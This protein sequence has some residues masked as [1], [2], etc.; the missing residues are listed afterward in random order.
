MTTETFIS[1]IKFFQVENNLIKLYPTDNPK[2]LQKFWERLFWIPNI[3][4]QKN[5]WLN[6]LYKQTNGIDLI[7][8]YIVPYNIY[9]N[10][11]TESFDD[12]CREWIVNQDNPNEILADF[13]SFMTNDYSLIGYLDNLKNENDDNYIAYSSVNKGIKDVEIIFSSIYKLYDFIIE[14]FI[15]KRE[16]DFS[17]PIDYWK[18]RDEELNKAYLNNKIMIYKEKYLYQNESDLFKKHK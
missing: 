1:K 13:Y 18:E 7:N 14:S 5:G 4:Q 6:D 3:N 8:Y 16:L 9:F 15:N 12:F 11:K 2:A 17:H 10:K